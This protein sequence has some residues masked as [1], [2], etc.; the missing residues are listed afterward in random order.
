MLF[1]KSK[2]RKV[3]VNDTFDLVSAIISANLALAL[4]ENVFVAKCFKIELITAKTFRYSTL[5]RVFQYLHKIKV[6][7]EDILIEYSFNKRRNP[8]LV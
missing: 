8:T 7:V 4:L 2:V 1:N 6:A 5:P 3:I